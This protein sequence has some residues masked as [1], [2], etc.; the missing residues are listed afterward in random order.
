M[1]TSKKYH[2]YTWT[3]TANGTQ[4]I[5]QYST[6]DARRVLA[7]IR[8]SITYRTCINVIKNAHSVAHVY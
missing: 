5:N 6:N 2:V 3:E 8:G 4:I 7:D 1:D